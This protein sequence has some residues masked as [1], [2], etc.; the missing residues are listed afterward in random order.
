MDDGR[1]SSSRGRDRRGVVTL[2]AQT[3][4]VPFETVC[5]RLAVPAGQRVVL[6]TGCFDI[7]HVGHVYFLEEA[8]RQGDV[9]VV[10]VNGDQ[11]VRAM[12][13]PRRPIVGEVQR[14]TLVAALR[15]VDYTFVYD[16][17]TADQQ[18]HALAPRVFVTGEESVSQYP[19][20]SEAARDVGARVHVVQRMHLYSTTSLM[21]NIQREGQ[22]A[23]GETRQ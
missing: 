17:V 21:E 9:L 20:E 1:A 2:G 7:M 4:P 23:S 16:S 12:K 5:E 8:S 14:A 15:C 10:G 6:A 3:G 13:G 22:G 18:I 19:A 11:S